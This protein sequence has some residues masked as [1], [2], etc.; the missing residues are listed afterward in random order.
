MAAKNP[1]IHQ[2]GRAKVTIKNGGEQRV[3]TQDKDTSHNDIT[4]EE[5][6]DQWEET[7][8]LRFATLEQNLHDPYI[9]SMI[10]NASGVGDKIIRSQYTNGKQTT[11][12]AEATLRKFEF[13]ESNRESYQQDFM[14]RLLAIGID[15]TRID[16]FLDAIT[17]EWTDGGR[18]LGTMERVKASIQRHDAVYRKQRTEIFVRNSIPESVKPFFDIQETQAVFDT[19]SNMLTNFFEDYI[20]AVYGE[21]EGSINRITVRRGI[22]TCTLLSQGLRFEEN[23]LC[24]FSLAL[25]TSEKFSQVTRKIKNGYCCILSTDLPVIQD[26]VIAFAPF[27]PKMCIKQMEFVVAPPLE[28]QQI[29]YS[30]EFEGI[31]EFTFGIVN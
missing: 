12:L 31:H 19:N 2:A 5:F 10:H 28:P 11:E 1:T 22:H 6:L 4:Y 25:T 20:L 15:Q 13:I 16:V 30:G 21:R 26:R 27:I 3:I 9:E 23:Q 14:E 7:D 8:L 29:I 24:S 18:N 17:N